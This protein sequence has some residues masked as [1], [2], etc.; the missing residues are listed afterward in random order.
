VASSAQRR[1]DIERR[2]WERQQQRR[3]EAAADRV[4]TWK[5]VGILLL[6]AAVA[7]GVIVAAESVGSDE[8]SITVTDDSTATSSSGACEYRQTGESAVA[9]IGVPAPLES[10]PAEVTSATMTINDAPVTVELLADEAPCTVHS[11]AHL[12][13]ANYFDATTCH[14]LTT[15][16]T[17]KVVQCGDPTGTGSGGPGYEFD[18]ENTD[19]ATYP[20]GTVAMA[21]AGPGTNGSQFFLVYADSQLP[22]DYTVFG[23]ITSGLEVITGI[24]AEG[25]ADGGTDGAPASPVIL[26]DVTAA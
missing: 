8:D 1:R 15:S 9:G 18:N 19:G 11:L 21:N 10:G 6:T 22:P 23:T 7:V 25:T 3:Q 2:K 16:D 13:A 26:A 4:R 5:L 12:A 20:A 14:R 24:A 17:L